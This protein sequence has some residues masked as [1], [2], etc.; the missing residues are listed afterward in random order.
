MVQESQ[1][2]VTREHEL[3][4]DG[5]VVQSQRVVRREEH[6]ASP[7][8]VAANVIW[9]VYGIVAGLHVIRF[10]LSLLGANSAN[11]FANFVYTV[12]NPFVSPFRSLFSVDTT[13]GNGTGRFE[14]ETLVALLVY[15]L[16]AWVLARMVRIKKEA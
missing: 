3:D 10:L 16:I 14:I 2:N 8:G 15:G 7:S 6:T 11:A 1:V 5:T 13:V 4:D 9:L 12:T